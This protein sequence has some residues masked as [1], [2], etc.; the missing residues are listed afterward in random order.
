M[1]ARRKG[2]TATDCQA[3]H[4]IPQHSDQIGMQITVFKGPPRAVYPTP[5]THSAVGTAR[6][7]RHANMGGPRETDQIGN[8]QQP[9]ISQT[10][11]PPVCFGDESR[12]VPRD[13]MLNLDTAVGWP[14]LDASRLVKLD[15]TCV[16]SWT[17]SSHECLGESKLGFHG[18]G[19]AVST[20]HTRVHHPG[21]PTHP[22]THADR[23][24]S[25]LHRGCCAAYLNTSARTSTRTNMAD[26]PPPVRG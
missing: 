7:Q 19:S 8:M 25:K 2:R 24:D 14:Q 26:C 13:D 6:N 22:G 5:V 4:V 9:A 1:Y 3:A 20:S 18:G 21:P 15:A 12:A 11:N 23:F 16:H 10:D 17:E